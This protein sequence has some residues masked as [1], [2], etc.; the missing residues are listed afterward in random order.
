MKARRYFLDTAYLLALAD[1]VDELH[2]V[3]S[4]WQAAVAK[5]AAGLLTTELVLIETVN[6][7]RKPAWRDVAVDLW[8]TLWR[9]PRVHVERITPELMERAMTLFADRRDKA[10]SL[11]DCLSFVV[12]RD[13][14]LSDALT[15]D[16]H[17]VQ[18]GFRALLLESP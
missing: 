1:A 8:R 11:T 18:A 16:Q 15:S 12:M 2:V 6:A 3:A 14:G 13:Q 7:L 9:D 5:G 17:F 10:W 4:R